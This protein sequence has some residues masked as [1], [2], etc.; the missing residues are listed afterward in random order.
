M[1]C[2]HCFVEFHENWSASRIGGE[3]L[4]WM[5]RVTPCPR[6]KEPIVEVFNPSNAIAHFRVW[7]RSV[8][9]SPVHQAVPAAMKD[10]YVEACEVLPVSPKASAAL[11]RRCLQH[12]LHSR[13]HAQHNLIDQIKAV[14]TETNPSKFLPEALRDNIDA[15]RHFGNFS[16]HP[17]NDRTTL[18]VIDVEP[19]EA[20]WCLELIEALFDFSFAAPFVAAERK[21]E[22]NTKL[23]QAGKAPA[24]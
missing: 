3:I 7:P 4:G 13:G 8:A 24:L 18:Q 19:H 15:V 22:L 17:I 12:I 11:S 14:L 16:A 21:K 2:P 23:R 10:D 1:Q 5:G 6:C 20:E 9:R